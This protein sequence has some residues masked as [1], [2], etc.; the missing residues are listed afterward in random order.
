MARSIG[1]LNVQ[2]NTVPDCICIPLY[3]CA[4]HPKRGQTLNQLSFSLECL[5]SC[6]R[7]TTTSISAQAPVFRCFCSRES[8]G[9]MFGGGRDGGVIRLQHA[10]SLDEPVPI[11]Q[12]FQGV[13]KFLVFRCFEHIPRLSTAGGALPC[14]FCACR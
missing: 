13:A 9:G 11:H 6:V 14:M 10:T 2:I 5:V 1:A 3:R 7:P 12:I 4:C 8:T